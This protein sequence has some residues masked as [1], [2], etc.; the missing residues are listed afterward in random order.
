VL[1][2]L[3]DIITALYGLISVIS[4]QIQGVLTTWSQRAISEAVVA[5]ENRTP[6]FERWTVWTCLKFQNERDGFF[7]KRRGSGEAINSGES[8]YLGL[9]PNAKSASTHTRVFDH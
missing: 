2:V 9:D 1:V 6:K 4:Q 8:L 5:L 3:R 7:S